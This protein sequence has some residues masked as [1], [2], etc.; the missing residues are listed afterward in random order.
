MIMKKEF[1][2]IEIA[3][4]LRNVGFVEPCIACYDGSDMLSTYSTVF[5]P[6]NYNVKGGAKSSAPLLQQAFRWFRE[7]YNLHSHIEPTWGNVN[8]WYSYLVKNLKNTYEF[9]HSAFETVEEAEL[10]CLKK[11]IDIVKCKEY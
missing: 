7:K 11:L 3:K 6:K 2:T 8:Y 5:N 4:Q 9:R 1:V 10:E